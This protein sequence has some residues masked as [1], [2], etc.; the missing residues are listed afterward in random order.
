MRDS[1]YRISRVLN[2]NF[3]SIIY[4]YIYSTSSIYFHQNGFYNMII[5]REQKKKKDFHNLLFTMNPLD[6]IILNVINL[7]V[8]LME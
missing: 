8:Y 6:T 1:Y 7:K 3:C 4:I 2:I 5:E